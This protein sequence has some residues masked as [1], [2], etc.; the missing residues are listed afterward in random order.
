[1][2]KAACWEHLSQWQGIHHVDPPVPENQG[3]AKK[4]LWRS[5]NNRRVTERSGRAPVLPA[6][7]LNSGKGGKGTC[8]G[9]ERV[10]GARE[11]QGC[12][13]V[14]RLQSQG[15]VMGTETCADPSCPPHFAAF[16]AERMYFRGGLGSDGSGELSAEANAATRAQ[17]HAVRRSFLAGRSAAGV[18]PGPG[19]AAGSA[20]A[21][22]PG[23]AAVGPKGAA[24]DHRAW[25]SPSGTPQCCSWQL[26]RSLQPKLSHRSMSLLATGQDTAPVA[27]HRSDS[28]SR[29]LLG[30]PL[31]PPC[32]I[33]P[34]QLRP[35]RSLPHPWAPCPWL[36]R[37]DQA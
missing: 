15:W 37:A 25:D 9:R 4:A 8:W 22:P 13:G 23:A 24:G 21:L 26:G 17:A 7:G 28:A 35:A 29:E 34:L 27:T 36:C 2:P 33:L 12:N 3:A 11:H 20:G 16:C 1:M 31:P 18:L 14:H 32:R 5:I 30:A 10:R 6:C 19:R